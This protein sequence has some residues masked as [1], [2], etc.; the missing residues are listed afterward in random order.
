MM[1]KIIEI[2]EIGK[3]YCM[4][5]F[6]NGEVKKINVEPLIKTHADNLTKDF[7]DFSV[8]KEVKIGSMGQLYWSN[9]S[10]MKDEAGNIISCEYDISPEFIFYN[11]EN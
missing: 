3:Y 8:F 2:T 9:C 5:M 7:F 6:S 4:C 1:N 11:S 10:T